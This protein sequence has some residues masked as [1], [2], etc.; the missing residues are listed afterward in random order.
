M[1]DQE[2]SVK[3]FESLGDEKALKYA[4]KHRDGTAQFGRFP[5]RN[6]ILGRESTLEEPSFLGRETIP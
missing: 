6:A 3:L 2:K 4:I 1:E 5:Y